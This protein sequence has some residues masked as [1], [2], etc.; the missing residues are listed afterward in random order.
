ME[1][2]NKAKKIMLFGVILVILIVA[3]MIGRR[4]PEKTS[5][6]SKIPNQPVIKSENKKVTFNC[7]DGRAIDV[8]FYLPKDEGIDIDLGDG[9]KITLKRALAASGARYSNTDESFVFWNKG[10]MAFIEEN[11]KTTYNNCVEANATSSV[12]STVAIANPASVNCKKVSGKL[13]LQKKPDGSEYGLCNFTDGRAC[14]E[15]ALMRGE[16]PVGGVKTAGFNTDA[17]K[18]CVWVGGQTTVVTTAVCTFK[19]GKTCK[20]EELYSGKCRP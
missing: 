20:V 16:C 12:S 1:N 3:L 17:Q 13:I 4:Q 8:T 18:Y 5:D 14:E 10:D 15:W 19:N 7:P 6:R 9:K 11:G 2:S